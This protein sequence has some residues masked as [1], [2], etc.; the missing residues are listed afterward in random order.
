MHR[1][2]PASQARRLHSTHAPTLPQVHRPDAVTFVS[3]EVYRA[4][5]FAVFFAQVLAAGALP[6]IGARH[7]RPAQ[8]GLRAG[9][10]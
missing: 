5:L 6:R 7:A 1:A 9:L 10:R 2:P 3:Q 8:Q 4:A